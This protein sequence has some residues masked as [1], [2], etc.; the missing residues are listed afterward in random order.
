M[1]DTIHLYEDKCVGCNKCLAEC[2]AEQA[3][4]A[5]VLEGKNK[6]RIN[7][8]KCI[9]CG[10]CIET[11]DHNAREYQDDTDTFFADLGKGQKISVIVA[12]AVR[13]NFKNYKNLFGFLK[14]RGVNL[15]Y[16]VS[17]GADITTWAYLKAIKDQNLTS[18]IAQPCPAIV[19]FI[20]KYHPELIER[21]APIHSPALCTAVYLKKYKDVTDKIAFLSPCLGK[22]QEFTDTNQL[23]SY[24]VT[25]KLLSAYLKKNNIRLD[26][27]TESDF[28]D[29]GCGIG[30]TFSRP[31]GLRENVDF[32][33]NGQAWVRQVEGIGHAYSYLQEYAERVKS[34]K[35]VPLL[36]DIL[37]CSNG[38]NLGTGTCKEISIDDVDCV[39]NDLKAAKIKQ[40]NKRKI[41]KTVYTLFEQF[42][43]ELNIKDFIRTYSDKSSMIDKQ[44]F[45]E[46][47]YDQVFEQMHKSDEVERGINCFAC[48]YGNCH[49]FARAVL[50]GNNHLDNCINYNR[51]EV[52]I[53]HQHVQEKIEE[54]GNLQHMYQEIQQLNAEKEQSTL[55]LNQNVAQI[56]T[57]IDE[58]ASGSNFNTTT[59]A[60]ISEQI[61]VIYETSVKLRDTINTVELKLNDFGKASNEI[62]AIS[63]QTN[64]LALNASIEAARA[65][66]QGR[67]FAVVAEEVRKLAEQTRSVVDSTKSSEQSIRLQNNELLEMANILEKQMEA[68]SGKV[69]EISATIEQTT[70]KCQQIAGAAKTLIN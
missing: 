56:T 4:A 23:V 64:L 70:A 52:A 21:L 25:Y 63:G 57:A 51:A 16:D 67:G 60:T 32:H 7:P 10:H 11:C 15:I 46:Q 17:F 53:E 59:I 5:Y 38:C 1:L 33:T 54:F 30:L 12:P 14:S 2:P 62:V 31:G 41:F 20:E 58:V 48:G 55:L 22:T 69:L 39:M 8:D 6:V 66:E 29:I 61:Q 26:S 43:K 36:V 49:S 24:N 44:D 40:K 3:N 34:N 65:G 13:F 19:T 45:S 50:M 68:V 42:D 37:N 18:V 9:L 27:F 47:A 28:D 35:H